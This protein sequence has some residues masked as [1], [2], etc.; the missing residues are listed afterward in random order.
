MPAAVPAAVVDDPVF[1]AAGE[2]AVLELLGLVTHGASHEEL[3][4]AVQEACRRPGVAVP[5]LAA[6]LIEELR[7]DGFVELEPR[8]QRLALAAKA[9][10]DEPS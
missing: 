8:L 4:P 3:L 6:R 9:R 5:F 2:D 7:R 10:R 1:R